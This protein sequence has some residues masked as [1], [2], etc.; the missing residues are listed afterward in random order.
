MTDLDYPDYT[1]REPG[2][3][4]GLR[5]F[6][7]AVT[8]GVVVLTLVVIGT[9]YLGGRRGFPGPG[10]VSVTAHVVA[11]VVVVAAQRFADRRR[12]GSAAAGSAVVLLVTVALLWTQWWG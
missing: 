9:A 5:A 10:A 3:V 7:G 11:A 4:R 6:S 2:A 8:A 1:A 12:G